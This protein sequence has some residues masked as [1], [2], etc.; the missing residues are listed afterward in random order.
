MSSL[1]PQPDQQPQTQMLEE[2]T[3][4]HLEGN[5]PPSTDPQQAPQKRSRVAKAEKPQEQKLSAAEEATDMMLAANT[6]FGEAAGR[7]LA[8]AGGAFAASHSWN[9]RRRR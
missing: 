1:P 7:D 2:V 3:P 8:I 9:L 4:A 5:N 6:L